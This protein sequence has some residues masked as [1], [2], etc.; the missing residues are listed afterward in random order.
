[1]SVGRSAARGCPVPSRLP[2][3]PGN[4]P[5]GNAGKE[6]VCA[7]GQADIAG[8]SDQLPGSAR[9]PSR[10]ACAA[11]EASIILTIPFGGSG[12]SRDIL[13]T[14]ALSKI[15][16]RTYPGQTA[17]TFTPRSAPSKRSERESPTTACLAVQSGALSGSGSRPARRGV[18]DVAEPLPDHDRISSERAVQD[19]VEVHVQDSAPLVKGQV[20]CGVPEVCSFL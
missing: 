9:T 16:V 12:G 3:L 1:M 14:T 7:P 4:A 8:E 19:A 2:H 18:H 11:F 15:G 5:L 10:I 13:T 20:T 17:L 6:A